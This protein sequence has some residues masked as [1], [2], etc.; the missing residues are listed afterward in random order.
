MN[1]SWRRNSDKLHMKLL[2]TRYVSASFQCSGLG[3][4]AEANR[5]RHLSPD[6][7]KPLDWLTQSVLKRDMMYSTVILSASLLLFKCPD[8][9]ITLY[10]STLSDALLVFLS[11]GSD[12]TITQG[13]RGWYWTWRLWSAGVKCLLMRWVFN[14]WLMT[15]LFGRE[16]AS[17]WCDDRDAVRKDKDKR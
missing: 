11:G 2:A 14:L 3:S 4:T 12:Q 1:H 10:T 8:I 17:G 16:M 6:W 15:L 7:L 9:I 13:G 5:H